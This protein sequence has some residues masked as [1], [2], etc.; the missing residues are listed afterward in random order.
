MNELFAEVCKQRANIELC[1][2]CLFVCNYL[3][4]C[5]WYRVQVAEARGKVSKVLFFYFCM[6]F[7]FYLSVRGK[8]REL[9]NRGREKKT[10]IN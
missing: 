9:L 7:S 1:E 4:V 6:M 8:A 5:A 2:F 3:V 10:E